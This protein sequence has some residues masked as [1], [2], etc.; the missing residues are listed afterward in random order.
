M[1]EA[2]LEAIRIEELL[3]HQLLLIVLGLLC[4]ILAPCAH[5]PLT[6]CRETLLAALAPAV[7]TAAGLTAAL[8]CALCVLA[9]P[10]QKSE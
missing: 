9:T 4:C 7:G 6:S 8:R 10:K 2:L 5:Y 3:H 1:L